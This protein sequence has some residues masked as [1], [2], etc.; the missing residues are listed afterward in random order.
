MEPRTPE[1]PRT[2][3]RIATGAN[4]KVFLWLATAAQSIAAVLDLADGDRLKTA[5]QMSLIVAFVLLATSSPEQS[6]FRNF[7]VYIALIVSIGL[8]VARVLAR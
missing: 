1:T 4:A 3:R 6:K 5:G 7:V 2:A 8:L